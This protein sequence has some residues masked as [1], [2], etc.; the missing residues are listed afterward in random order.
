V[1]EKMMDE[2][3]TVYSDPQNADLPSSPWGGDGRAMRRRTW[4]E[5]GVVRQL[6][7]S[8][9]WAAKQEVEAVPLPSNL[10]MAG[11][12]ASVEQLIRDTTRGVLL[13]RTWY[14]RPVDPQTLLLTGLTRDG[15]FY[16][17]NGAIKHAV[18]NLRFN[19][20]PVITLNNLDALARAERERRV[21][22]PVPDPRDAGVDFTFTS[23]S[24][25][26]EK[27]AGDG[28]GQRPL[29]SAVCHLP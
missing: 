24:D 19:E 11:G 20:S 21:R 22:V 15:T 16:I 4:I 8:R 29:P 1:G 26:V 10:I 17:E 2:R 7:Y 12:D 14:I 3:V 28:S 5:N 23:L 18:K 9:Y 27:A 13:T 25:A 6:Y